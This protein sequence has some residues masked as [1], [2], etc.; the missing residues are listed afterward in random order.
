MLLCT[1]FVVVGVCVGR[2]GW[3]LVSWHGVGWVRAVWFG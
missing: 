2:R 1:D 3:M